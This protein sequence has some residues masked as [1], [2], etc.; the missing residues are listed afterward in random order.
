MTARDVIDQLALYFGQGTNSAKGAAA[1]ALDR[2]VAEA[3]ERA[4][5][6]ERAKAAQLSQDAPGGAGRA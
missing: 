2:Y 4:L 1:G 5:Q 3:V 6:A